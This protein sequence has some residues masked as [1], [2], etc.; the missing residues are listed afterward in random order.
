M[1]GERLVAGKRIAAHE[2]DWL[3]SLLTYAYSITHAYSLSE[4]IDNVN[5]S[6][7]QSIE[8]FV[9]VFGVIPLSFVLYLTLKI[10][11]TCIKN[12]KYVNV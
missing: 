2:P 12:K 4:I 6:N 5:T 3:D 8:F 1:A 10:Y 11:F 9:I 7:A